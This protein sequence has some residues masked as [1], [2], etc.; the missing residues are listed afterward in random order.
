[1]LK[2]YI[3]R[4]DISSWLKETLHAELE[5]I[6]NIANLLN[7]NFQNIIDEISNIKWKVIIIGMWKSWLVGKKIA[8]TLASTWTSSFFVHPWEAFHG[9]LWMITK[10]D[11]VIMLSNSW[12]TEELVKLIPVIKK[13][14]WAKI[15][16]ITWNP[17]SILAN[18]SDYSLVY[19]IESEWYLNLPPMASTTVQLVIWD[20]IATALMEK[21]DFR[22]EDFALFHPWGS[23]WKKLLLNIENILEKVW[24]ESEKISIEP[25]ANLKD[26]IFQI[27][28]WKKWWVVIVD[29]N[30]KVLWVF[31]DW[32]LRR[33]IKEKG[34][35]NMENIKILDI[36][37]KEP[38]VGKIK[39]KAVDILNLME[40]NNITFLP[41]V[42]DNWKLVWAINIHDL[43]KEG[44]K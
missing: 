29:K 25:D 35:S 40:V 7:N 19:N 3:L 16:W 15:I 37:T 10:D 22:K 11:I 6:I 27:T 36:M 8:A 30:N 1:M 20:L 42:D 43:I 28:E 33:T 44:I 17:N 38:K 31:T 18:D 21:R 26:T 23:L 41:I 13:Y 39:E 9:D 24:V 5:W 34:I 4:L 32:D 12:N 14:I 2:D